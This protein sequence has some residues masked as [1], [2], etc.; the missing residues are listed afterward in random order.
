MELVKNHKSDAKSNWRKRGMKFNDEE[1]EFIYSVY[2]NTFECM[3]CSKVFKKTRDRHLDHNHETGEIR[4]VLC[5]SC[6]HRIDLVIDENI[7]IHDLKNT[8]QY[9]IQIRRKG[10][11]IVKKYYSKNKYTIEFVREERDKIL[12]NIS[13]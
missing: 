2:I 1:F 12:K 6:N 5:N 4:Y 7:Y 9:S 10:K 3:K 13:M 8:N 11:N